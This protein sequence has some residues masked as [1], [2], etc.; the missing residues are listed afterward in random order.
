MNTFGVVLRRL[1]G[2][3]LMVVGIASASWALLALMPGD[4]A[5]L[6]VGP[7]ASSRDVAAVRKLYGLDRPLGEQWITYAKHLVHIAPKGDAHDAEHA[8]CAEL[9]PRVHV[10]LGQSYLYRQPVARL[11]EKRLP[12]SLALG[13]GAFLVQLL[14]GGASGIAAAARARSRLDEL[15]VGGSLLLS[16]VPTFVVGL[17]LQYLCAYRLGVL[18][19]DG[20]GKTAAEHV[21]SLVLPSLA[22]GLY[23]AATFSR[24]VREEVRD[25]LAGQHVR[26]ATAKGASRL[27]VIVVHGVR[28]ALTPIATLAALD[29]G[30]L[31][32]GAIVVEKIFRIPGLGEMTVNAVQNRD[33]QAVVG[34]V[35]V[36]STAIVVATLLADLLAFVLDPRTRR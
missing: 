9:V 7:Q 16:T 24:L 19:L 3:V 26:T 28:V 12:V 32:G 8:G 10:D 35:L 18:P 21:R 14:L 13:L 27:R 2:A 4:P 15:V 29:L 17:G 23:G 5:R 31:V 20:Y 33:A 1:V 25:A 36:S 34:A 6:L 11:V 22:L 30:A